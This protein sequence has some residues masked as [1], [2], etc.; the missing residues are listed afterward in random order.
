MMEGISHRMVSV[1]AINMHV[2]EKGHGP[3]V[4]LRAL[5][6]T[7]GYR[8]VAPSYSC[9]HVAADIESLAGGEPV[10]LV[11]HDWSVGTS[12]FSAQIWSGHSSL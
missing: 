9:L 7:L 10:F 11:A 8:T 1:N 3:T 6:L 12:A 2:A 5:I 4:L